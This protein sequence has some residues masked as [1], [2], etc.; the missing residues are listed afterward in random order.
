MDWLCIILIWHFLKWLD[1][2][3]G[4]PS[5]MEVIM[6]LTGHHDV[7]FALEWFKEICTFLLTV[8]PMVYLFLRVCRHRSRS[9]FRAYRWMHETFDVSPIKS[10]KT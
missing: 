9:V 8:I 10:K 3:L 1:D 4:V 2:Y 6:N 5:P 7:M